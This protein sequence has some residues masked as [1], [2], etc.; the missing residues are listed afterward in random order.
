M[1][2]KSLMTW[3][4]TMLCLAVSTLAFS[5]PAKADPDPP[6]PPLGSGDNGG[7]G[8]APMIPHIWIIGG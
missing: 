1:K 2:L 8:G 6:N 7:G 3:S 5:E 4:V